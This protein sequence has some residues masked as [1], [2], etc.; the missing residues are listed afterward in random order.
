[1]VSSDG[2]AVSDA[3]LVLERSEP[4]SGDLLSDLRSDRGMG[5]MPADA[6]WLTYLRVDAK[7]ADLTY[8]LAVDATGAG[9]P[10][11]VQAGLEAPGTHNG[12]PSAPIA[13]IVALSFLGLLVLAAT[14]ERRR[15][16]G[17]F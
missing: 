14:S 11:P 12:A 3:G 10:S 16:R 17:A 4:A 6:M 7:A 13:I 1:P 8:D 15:V 9:R 2:T 5:W